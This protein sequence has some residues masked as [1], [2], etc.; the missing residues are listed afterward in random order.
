MK[1][2][3]EYLMHM[4]ND[5]TVANTARVSMGDCTNWL[6]LPMS[7]SE[8]QRDSLIVYL[9]REHHT[10]PFRHTG[11]SIRG[12]VPLFIARQLGKHQVG[13]TWNEESRRYVDNEPEFFD[14]TDTWRARPPKSIKQG[15]AGLLPELDQF[16]VNDLY[17][18][19]VDTCLGTY[20][21]MLSMNVAPEQARMVLPQSMMVNFIWTGSLMAFAHVYALRIDQHAQKE[22][23][24]FA[25]AIDKIMRPL[26]PK[27]WSA[28][29]GQK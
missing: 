1:Q 18:N 16:V 23:R 28:L 10:S 19:V 24:D 3:V 12:H 7:Y 9:A 17:D 15:S 21:T 4:G 5:N 8:N 25:E 14:P 11:I 20:Q 2:M 26:F 22:A 27:S 13:L 6:E 29:T